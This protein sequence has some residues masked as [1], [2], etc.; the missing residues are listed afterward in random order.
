VYVTGPA[1]LTM[2]LNS[3]ADDSQLMMTL[4]TFAIIALILLIIYRSFATMLLVTITV[5][6]E[7]SAARGV[8]AI[9]GHYQVME[10]SNLAVNLLTML[11]IA[12]ATDY[13]IFFL[14]RY[15]EARAAGQDRIAAYYTTYHSVSHVV[16]GSGL[17]IAGATLCLTFTRLPYFAAVGIPNAV[18]MLVIVAA[19]LTLTPAVL[20]VGTRFGL[21]ESK[22]KIKTRG[23]RRIGTALV[24]WP[25]PILVV[26][27]IVSLIGLGVLPSYTVNYNDRYYVPDRMPS[28]QGYQASDRHFSKAKMDPDILLIVADQDLRTPANMLILDRIAR[29]ILRVEGIN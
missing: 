20:L 21:L 9:L 15:H 27:M 13:A 1:A 2:D 23:W 28:I 19:A 10:L 12:A 6:V 3:A 25:G 7:L 26:T 29:N 14:G 24:R 11:G 8:V 4:I 16:L 18:A 22:R 17:A 5:F